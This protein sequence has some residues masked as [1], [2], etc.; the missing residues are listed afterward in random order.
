[1]FSPDYTIGDM[2]LVYSMLLWHFLEMQ[3]CS[4]GQ[5]K[6]ILD[7][8]NRSSLKRF[9]IMSCQTCGLYIGIPINWLNFN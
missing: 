6:L 3:T 1:M 9:C 2:G 5:T 4:L 8:H 7:G